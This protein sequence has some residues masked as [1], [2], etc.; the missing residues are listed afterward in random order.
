MRIEIVTP[1]AP[2][3][4]HHGNR[5]TAERWAGLLGELGHTVEI[6]TDWSGNGA[7]LLVALHARKSAKSVHRFAAAH[8]ERPVV[9]A[10][11]GTDLYRDLADD[12]T[13]QASLWRADALVVLQPLGVDKVPAALRDRVHVIHQSVVPP[14]DGEAVRSDVFEVAVLAHLREVKDPF[15]AARAARRL[16]DDSTVEV[17]HCGAPLDDGTAE[18]AAAEDAANPRWRWLG[19]RPR[20]EAMRLLARARLLAVTSH[21]EGGANV[22]GEAVAVG[23]PVISTRIAGSVGL[24]GADYPGYVEVGDAAGLAAAFRRAETDPAFYDDLRARVRALQLLFDP[25][26]ERARWAELLAGL[27]HREAGDAP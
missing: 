6:T 9:L 21:L 7:D 17:V 4:A 2:V 26:R 23:T 8:P 10:L 5:T 20:D 22:V 19:A 18:A 3:E 12:H 11:T 15:L 14:P 27:R 13:A 16:P 25:A 1:A 24:L